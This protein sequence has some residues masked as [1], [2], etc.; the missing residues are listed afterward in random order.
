MDLVGG[1]RT[2]AVAGAAVLL[3]GMA[4]I[5]YGVI[6]DDIS[7]SVSGACLTMPALTLIALVMVRRWVSDTRDERRFLAAAQRDA[8]QERSR[9]VAAQSALEGERSRL[10]RDQAA[11]RAQLAAKLLA[12]RGAMQAEFE[13]Q[14]ATLAAE[15]VEATVL[16]FRDGKFA[17]DTLPRGRVIRFP[18][19]EPGA[20]TERGRAREH[21]V[22][23]P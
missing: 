3:G 2:T 10:A 8:E 19:Q 22:V 16:M 18:K 14:R 1:T 21:G 13:E 12:E 5:L 6:V 11:E 4:V 9:Y 23:G 17:P 15:T 7:R 20:S